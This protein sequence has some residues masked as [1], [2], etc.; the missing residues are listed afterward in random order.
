M[1]FI[2]TPRPRANYTGTRIRGLGM[3]RRSL[4]I[5]SCRRSQACHRYAHSR[6]SV[7]GP[8]FAEWSGTSLVPLGVSTH[9]ISSTRLGSGNAISRAYV[10][11]SERRIDPRDCSWYM[12]GI[13]PR[14]PLKSVSRASFTPRRGS[15]RLSCGQAV[16]SRSTTGA[17][18]PEYTEAISFGC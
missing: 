13:V 8:L 17:C 6:A 4:E 11:R 9:V 7:A 18:V 15:M 12:P 14:Q 1:E 16:Q 10:S 3:L 2:L 5:V